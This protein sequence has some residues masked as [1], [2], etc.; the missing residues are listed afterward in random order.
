MEVLAD[1]NV[2]EEYVAALRGDGHD[3]VYTRNVDELGPGAAD[4]AIVEYAESNT[5]AII[6]TDAKDFSDLEADV[7]VFIAPQDMNGGEVRE[8]VERIV[9]MPLDPVRADPL[10]LSAL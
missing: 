9:S 6:T 8:A 3:V 7:A 10:W 5:R 4:P 1:A 2:P